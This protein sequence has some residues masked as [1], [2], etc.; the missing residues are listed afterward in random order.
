MPVMNGQPLAA[1]GGL[2]FTVGQTM[3]ELPLTVAT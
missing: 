2:G 3:T 1:L